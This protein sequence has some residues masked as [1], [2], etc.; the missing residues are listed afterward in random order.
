DL[1][2]GI[3]EA[4]NIFSD[5]RVY[6]DPISD[7]SKVQFILKQKCNVSYYLSDA[8]GHVIENGQP[9]LYEQGDHFLPV[10]WEKLQNSG[11]YFLSIK[12]DNTLI[13]KKI[14]LIK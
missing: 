4:N 8:L 7:Y 1:S 2:S 14:I 11:F 6:P 9:F 13:N 5:V 12:F 10:D 3:A